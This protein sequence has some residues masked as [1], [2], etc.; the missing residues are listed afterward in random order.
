MEVNTPLNH[1]CSSTLKHV[2]RRERGK[3]NANLAYHV[4]KILLNLNWDQNF[5]SAKL[6]QMVC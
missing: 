2:A 6:S 4:V 3:N 5:K 1:M